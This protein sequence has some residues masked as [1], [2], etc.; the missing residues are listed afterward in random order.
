MATCVSFRVAFSDS[1]G[2]TSLFLRTGSVISIDIGTSSTRPLPS[3]LSCRSLMDMKPSS[4]VTLRPANG[5]VS[6]RFFRS[7]SAVHTGGG[8]FWLESMPTVSFA[9][10]VTSPVKSSGLNCVSLSALIGFSVA[11]SATASAEP[12]TFNSR[13]PSRGFA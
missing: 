13:F 9:F 8:G 6:D 4:A 11:S 2:A 3:S 10:A 1:V 12:E 7:R 5:F